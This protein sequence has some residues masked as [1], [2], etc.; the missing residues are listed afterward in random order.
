MAAAD[1][2]IA[3]GIVR[4]PYWSR[5]GG[6]EAE[7]GRFDMS[8]AAILLVLRSGRNNDGQRLIDAGRECHVHG[9]LT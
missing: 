8:M 2:A 4:T 1:S 6:G 3:L 7:A 5:P 9:I